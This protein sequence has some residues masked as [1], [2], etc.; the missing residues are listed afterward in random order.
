MEHLAEVPESNDDKYVTF[1]R[2]EFIE[3]VKHNIL[4][5]NEIEVNDAVVI[6]RQDYFAAPA[7]ATYASM[8][9]TALVLIDDPK[10]TAQ[11]TVIADYFQRQS[12]IAG[13]ESWKFP[14]L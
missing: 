9:A 11:L 3:M 6:R 7:L 14:D 5:W 1:K 2:V 13:D 4:D 8:I 12:E 10:R